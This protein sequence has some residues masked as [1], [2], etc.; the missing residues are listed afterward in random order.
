MSKHF[1]CDT[2]D[3]FIFYISSMFLDQFIHLKNGY[4]INTREKVRKI[5]FFDKIIL[6]KLAKSGNIMKCEVTL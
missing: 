5:E 3:V 4:F 6:L 2:C 1:T